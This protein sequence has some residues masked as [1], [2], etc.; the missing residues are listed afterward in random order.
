VL[1]TAGPDLQDNVLMTYDTHDELASDSQAT[2][3]QLHAFFLSQGSLK[4]GCP[5]GNDEQ[6]RPF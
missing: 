6:P 4:R 2:V 1:S 3:Q 5:K